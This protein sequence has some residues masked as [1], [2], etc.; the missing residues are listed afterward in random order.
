MIFKKLLPLFLLTGVLNIQASEGEKKGEEQKY[1]LSHFRTLIRVIEDNQ[2][3][4]V[5]AKGLFRIQWDGFN[6]EVTVKQVA[7]K[8]ASDTKIFRLVKILAKPYGGR[9]SWDQG[10]LSKKDLTVVSTDPFNDERCVTHD[11]VSYND[12][13]VGL[14]EKEE[15]GGHDVDGIQHSLPNI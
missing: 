12:T 2:N 10:T 14:F 5:E 11:V 13:I 3:D 4:Y 7:K 15:E 6:D 9:F 8:M 1:T